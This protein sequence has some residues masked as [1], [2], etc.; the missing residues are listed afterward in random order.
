M[1]KKVFTTFAALFAKNRYVTFAL[2]VIPFCFAAGLLAYTE[3][4]REQTNSE[5]VVGGFGASHTA[6]REALTII[7][8]CTFII[9]SFGLIFKSQNLVAV[10]GV[11]QKWCAVAMFVVASFDQDTAAT[12][13]KDNPE[14]CDPQKMAGVD[15]NQLTTNLGIAPWLGYICTIIWFCNGAVLR[16]HAA[17]LQQEADEAHAAAGG[18]LETAAPYSGA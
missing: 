16:Q 11:L 4:N 13:C 5:G 15:P 9:G 1:V 12:F 10:C 6:W 3:K 7:I 2:S 18:N 14:A 8:L 17:M